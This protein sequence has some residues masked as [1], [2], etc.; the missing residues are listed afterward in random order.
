MGKDKKKKKPKTKVKNK[1]HFDGK[2][3]LGHILNFIAILIAFFTLRTAEK[4][5]Q[6]KVADLEAIIERIDKSEVDRLNLETR[7]INNDTE[8]LKGTNNV[9]DYVLQF[10]RDIEKIINQQYFESSLIDQELI[11]AVMKYDNLTEIERRN[12][13]KYIDIISLNLEINKTIENHSDELKSFVKE[14]SPVYDSLNVK[15]YNAQMPLYIEKLENHVT[16]INSDLKV[17]I[18]SLTIVKKSIYKTIIDQ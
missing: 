9:W 15:K 1:F 8:I 17:T 5:L 7:G 2:I 11:L 10:N 4:D 12:F 16:N 13:K 18:D 3:D 14:N 6:T